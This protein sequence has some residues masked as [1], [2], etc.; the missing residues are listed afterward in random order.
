M[1]M[2]LKPGRP[3]NWLQNYRPISLLPVMSN[4]IDRIVLRRLQEEIN[5]LDNTS[6]IPHN[7]TFQVPRI[8]EQ[9]K[10]SYKDSQKPIALEGASGPYLQGNAQAYPIV[11]PLDGVQGQADRAAVH[12]QDRHS[13]SAARLYTLTPT[14]ADDVCIFT[15]SRDA[16]IMDRC[17]Q[18]VPNTLAWYA[19]WRI[20]IHPKKSTA[21]LFPR[22]GLKR[23]H[24][25][26]VEVT[27]QRGDLRSN[28]WESH[29]VP[30]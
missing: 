27:F 11:S 12:G 30:K 2:I 4:I 28:T 29:C 3:A 13:S 25:N 9:I 1:V 7:I 21:V 10:K 18:A 8:V 20:A 26:P 19:K 22:N 6:T 15:R 5:D 24:G 14:Y 23:R 16:R 17:L